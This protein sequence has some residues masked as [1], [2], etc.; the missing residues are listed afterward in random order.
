MVSLA[1][2]KQQLQQREKQLREQKLPQ[3]SQQFLRTRT[4]GQ[5]IQRQ[6]AERSL[7]SQQQRQIQQL[8][9]FQQQVQQAEQAKSAFDKFQSDL[10]DAKALAAGKPVVGAGRSVRKLAQL[11]KFKDQALTAQ[12]SLLNR[13]GKLG[14]N[15]IFSNGGISGFESSKLGQSFNLENLPN[16]DPVSAKA[17]GLAVPSL[18][19]Q[20]SFDFRSLSTRVAK[21]PLAAGVVAVNVLG[22]PLKFLRGELPFQQRI[23]Q[24]LSTREEST[25]SKKVEDFISKAKVGKGL[26]LSKEEADSIRGEIQSSTKG[27]IQK[28]GVD[29]FLDA[30]GII[31]AQPSFLG[32]SGILRGEPAIEKG[33]VFT[34]LA[35]L[36]FFAKKVSD[37]RIGQEFIKR[38]EKDVPALQALDLLSTSTKKEV[39]GFLTIAQ[40]GAFFEP[41]FATGAA[42]TAQKVVQ[43]QKT[44][45]TAPAKKKVSFDELSD[46]FKTKKTGG[47]RVEAARPLL[48]QIK[49]TND[50]VL[51]AK[52]TQILKDVL[53]RAY[54]EKGAN[55]VLLD[56]LEQEGLVI[57]GAGVK[58]PVRGVSIK[59]PVK[60]LPKQ[61]TGT[62][63]TTGV[64]TQPR[65]LKGIPRAVGGAGLTASQIAFAAGRPVP[66]VSVVEP[67]S[68]TKQRS[69]QITQ[70]SQQIRALDSQIVGA[71]QRLGQL[72]AQRADQSL[73]QK[74]RELALALQLERQKTLQKQR[75]NLQSL[76][77]QALR[78]KQVP[79]QKFFLKTRLSSATVPRFKTKLKAKLRQR[80]KFKG[81]PKPKPRPRAPFFIP[82]PGLGEPKKK[83]LKFIPFEISGKSFDVKVRR[84]GKFRTIAKSLPP[85]R[86]KRRLIKR[87]SST[88]AASGRIVPSTKPPVKKDIKRIKVPKASFRLPKRGSPLRKPGVFTIVEKRNK[89]ITRGTGEVSEIAAARRAKKPFRADGNRMSKKLKRRRKR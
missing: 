4:R 60:G 42:G 70:N 78:Q 28:G 1:Q 29:F 67:L 64:S 19:K 2:V 43:K 17:L 38:I 7:Q 76:T 10:R 32:V 44:K 71:K 35:P 77:K 23:E 87:L 53:R 80:F 86:A 5:S 36:N 81:K 41:A 83:K 66:E 52:Q 62:G 69:I 13:F 50:P 79:K 37:S 82:F 65:D 73:I 56:L 84:G 58:P 25:L 24:K 31:K 3:Q 72:V 30:E 6:Q 15:P 39:I 33:E 46:F 61:I 11:I 49:K 59:P 51:K 16:V 18:P 88:L 12:T 57:R 75:Q 63:I 20:P 9:P 85:N 8:Q 54:G 14:L 45:K 47:E 21:V 40:L 26:T 34:P 22:A 89:R 48:D 27:F 55:R 68:L 74:Q